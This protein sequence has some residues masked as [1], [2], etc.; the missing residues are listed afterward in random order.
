MKQASKKP[1]KPEAMVGNLR[2]KLDD[3]GRN[4]RDRADK[5]VKQSRKTIQKR[6]L[7]SVGVGIAAGAVA[8]IVAGAL[9]ARRKKTK[10]K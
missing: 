6:P 3:R 4:V 5:T 8:G 1:S 10:S 2:S 9:V 7:T